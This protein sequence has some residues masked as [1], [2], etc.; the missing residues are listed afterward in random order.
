MARATT[1]IGIIACMALAGCGDGASRTPAQVRQFLPAANSARCAHRATTTHCDVLV[2][3]APGGVE[4]WTCEFTVERRPDPA[5]YAGTQSCW[6][7][8]GRPESLRLPS[9]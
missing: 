8:H 2:G 3:K 4:T 1:L 6:S 7:E 9:D 5:A